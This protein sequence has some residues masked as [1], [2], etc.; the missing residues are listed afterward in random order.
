MKTTRL[1]LPLLLLLLCGA[2]CARAD[3]G[4][5]GHAEA[6]AATNLPA[7]VTAKLSCLRWFFTHASVGGNI[8]TG[9]NV[10]HEGNPARYPLVIYGY[11]GQNG[12]GDYHGAVET[13]GSEGSSTY[14]A[15]SLPST[16]SNGILYE[17]QRGN[18]D[19]SNK[20][21]CFSNSVIQS[22][23]RFPKVNVVM[24]KFCWI[25]PY[26]DPVQYCATLSGLE[27]RFPQ[28]LFVYMTIPLTTETAGSE[29]DNRNA[30]N[31]AVRQYCLANSKWLLDVADLEAWTTAGVQQTY[32]SGGVT[33]QRMVSSFAVDP[34]GGDFHLNLAGRR[35]VA[36]GWYALAGALFAADR[37]GDGLSD[38]DELLAG[39]CPTNASDV[40]SAAVRDVGQPGRMGLQWQMV[41]GRVYSIGQ[42]SSLVQPG[43]SNAVTNLS[44]SGLYTHT[45]DVSSVDSSYFRLQAR[46]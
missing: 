40:L 11:D 8:I 33:N 36:L 7:D 34:G 29:N 23:W 45:T 43:W 41:T 37:D 22:G 3:G 24:D 35:Q 15:S 2:E 20:I 42:S 44:G 31:Q 18:P 17:C 9:M 46:Q 10:L 26:A 27:G 1:M 13:E 38:G 14:R 12:D 6:A 5:I 25:D 28:T 30:F 21:T 39:T 4:L 19:W 32:V 16:T